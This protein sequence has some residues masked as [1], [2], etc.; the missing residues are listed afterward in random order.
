MWDRFPSDKSSFFLV[1]SL[2][3]CPWFKFHSCLRI[4]GKKSTFWWYIFYFCSFVSSGVSNSSVRVEWDVLQFNESC[5][6]SFKIFWWTNHTNSSYYQQSVSLNH[7]VV[8]IGSLVPDTA[9][10]FQVNLR[11]SFLQS[12][13]P[14]KITLQSESWNIWHIRLILCCPL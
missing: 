3:N 2:L 12:F 10:Y 5:V 7:R 1:V 13:T 9:Y 4:F 11:N 6:E 14:Q 8:T